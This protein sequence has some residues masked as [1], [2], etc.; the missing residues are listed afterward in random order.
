MVI[1]ARDVVL[2]V[3]PEVEVARTRT[4]NQLQRRSACLRYTMFVLDRTGCA[5]TTGAALN[6]EAMRQLNIA[7][8]AGDDA[9]TVF[10]SLIYAE[11]R[12]PKE[13]DGSA[14]SFLVTWG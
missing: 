4:I 2:T 7:V 12:M 1:T 14:R 13:L 9:A 11:G 5:L 8:R 10:A 3:W 6:L